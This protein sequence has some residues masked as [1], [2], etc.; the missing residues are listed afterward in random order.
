MLRRA[1]F[2]GRY[3]SRIHRPPTRKPIVHS[4]LL[5]AYLPYISRHWVNQQVLPPITGSNLTAQFFAGMTYQVPQ[6]TTWEEFL[7]M[8]TIIYY[9]FH[10]SRF[11]SSSCGDE[12]RIIKDCNRCNDLFQLLFR[13]RSHP[14]PG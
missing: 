3:F 7:F 11:E 5:S 10:H 8:Q 14:R 12:T 1:G 4:L 9:R 13:N 6:T 2:R